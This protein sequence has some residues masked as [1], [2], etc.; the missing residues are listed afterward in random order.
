MAGSWL[1]RCAVLLSACTLAQILIG[2]VVTSNP[3]R[4]LYSLGKIH[5]GLGITVDVLTLGLALW[6]T[7]AED[8]ARLRGLGRIAAL[9]VA[10]QTVLGLPEDPEPA[11][12][13]SH[14]FLAQLFCGITIALAIR[15]SATIELPG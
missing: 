7:G 3:E 14:A 1:H 4:P 13:F 12:R 5:P 9:T 11:V 15:C 6:L 2:A 10:V 8:G